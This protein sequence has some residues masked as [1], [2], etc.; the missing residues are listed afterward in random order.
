M[1]KYIYCDDID[2]NPDNVLAT[3]YAAKKYYVPYLA[4]A[5]VAFLESSLTAK[6]ACLL[7]SQS[8]LFEEEGL[9]QRSWEVNK[10]KIKRTLAL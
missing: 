6:N 3:L 4:N 1:L 8:R 2:I 10:M 5:C 7:L 9:M